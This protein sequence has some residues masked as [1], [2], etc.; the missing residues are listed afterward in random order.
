MDRIAGK[1]NLGE[2]RAPRLMVFGGLTE[3]T[4]SG[5]G[6]MVESLNAMGTACVA[7]TSR[8]PCTIP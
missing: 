2:Y 6:A 5:T 7:N 4:A 8:S 3:L 1:T